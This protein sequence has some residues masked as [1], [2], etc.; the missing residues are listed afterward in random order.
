[1]LSLSHTHARLPYETIV[2]VEGT[3]VSV[4]TPVTSCTQSAVEILV[5]KAR[6]A[7]CPLM[8]PLILI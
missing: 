3:L 8:R 4:P 1:M 6:E 7:S 5:T 2:D